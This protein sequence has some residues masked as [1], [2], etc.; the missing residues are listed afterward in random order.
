MRITVG[1]CDPRKAAGVDGIPGSVV[2]LLAEQRPS[3]LLTVING[4]NTCGK[5]PVVWKEA[6]VVLIP[7]PGKDHA[8][9]SAYRPISILPA[10]SKVWEHTLKM[11]IER[12]IGQN[13]FHRDQNGFRRKWGTLESLDR[14]LAVAE[15]CRRKDLVCVLVALDVKNAFN[16]LRW[17]RI[18]EEIRWRRLSG[19]LQELLAD[20]LAERRILVH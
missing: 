13:P 5:I 18:M 7:K 3:V 11:L 2:R 9:S 17:E 4:I 1:K 20:Y 8:A 10:L 15:E 6:R 12:S 14:T 16:T 19:R